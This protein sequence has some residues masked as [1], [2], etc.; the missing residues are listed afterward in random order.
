MYEFATVV[1]LGLIVAKLVDLV[2][3]FAG[4]TPAT[5]LALAVLAGLGLAWAMDYSMFAGWS[6]S[7]REPWMGTL[8]TGLAIGGLAAF[9]HE[10]LDAFSSYARRSHDQATE[11]E[12]RI[13]RA[14]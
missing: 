9:W 10:V 6:V 2:R 5:R 3:H 7:F 8:A 4:V 11:I 13:P 14:A 12:T 1:L